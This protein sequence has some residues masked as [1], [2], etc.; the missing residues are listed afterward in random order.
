MR[1]GQSRKR[2]ANEQAIV[3]ALRAVGA[4]IVRISERNAPDLLV[5]FRGANVLLEIKA[6]K[7]LV[8]ANQAAWRS[9]WQ[10]QVAIVR[11][12]EEALVAIGA[13]R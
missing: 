2:D 4:T 7:G 12:A 1:V 3:E 13:I 11:S 6:E 9:C 8:R 5:G 10:G